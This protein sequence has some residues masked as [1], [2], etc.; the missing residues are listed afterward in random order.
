[1]RPTAA[2]LRGAST[3]SVRR[4][5]RRVGRNKRSAL[6]RNDRQ[7]W[8]PAARRGGPF[9]RGKDIGLTRLSRRSGAMRYAYCAL[10]ATGRGRSN[11]NYEPS[12]VK[13]RNSPIMTDEKRHFLPLPVVRATGL[14]R[15]KEHLSRENRTSGLSPRPLPRRSLRP[16]P[17]LSL[18][19]AL[20][21]R[22]RRLL[23]PPARRAWRCSG[24][25]R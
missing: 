11:K 6:R 16:R 5:H 1:L 4:P 9:G 24:H 2:S 20:R 14:G 25:G 8:T 7:A 13:R 22:R 19:P 10:R 17:P 21:S 15:S 3:L 18:H 23:R 12:L